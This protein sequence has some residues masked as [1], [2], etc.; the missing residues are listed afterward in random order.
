VR[1]APDFIRALATAKCPKCKA[2]CKLLH[3]DSP[4]Y[5]REINKTCTQNQ[6][7]PKLKQNKIKEKKIRKKM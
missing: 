3:P 1:D 4:S 5:Q 7:H 6:L 2:L